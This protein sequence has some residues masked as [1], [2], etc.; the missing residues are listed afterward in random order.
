M[1]FTNIVSALMILA[2]GGAALAQRTPHV[3]VTIADQGIAPLNMLTETK[4]GG[5]RL[6]D[7]TTCNETDT[8]ELVDFAMVYQRINSGSDQQLTLYDSQVVTRILG[9]FQ[10]R[11]V[12]SKLFKSGT[13]ASS[14]AAIV[15]AAF[16]VDP[17]IG[18]ALQIAPQIYGAILPVIHSRADIAA[19]AADI[20]PQNAGVKLAGHSCRAGLVVARTFAAAIR[21]QVLLVQ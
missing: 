9:V 3:T 12:F 8:D 17:M 21:T 13:A 11:N 10:D 16:R 14:V 19:L 5:T 15:T 2:I 18:A 7:A 20:L 4:V 1:R 6:L